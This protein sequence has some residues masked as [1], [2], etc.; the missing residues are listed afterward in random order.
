MSATPSPANGASGVFYDTPL[1]MKFNNPPALGTGTMR[2]YDSGDT[3]VD[4]IDLSQNQAN[5]AQNRTIGGATYYSYPVI[6]RGNHDKA[7]TGLTDLAYFNPV[8]QIAAR[9]TH[10][11]LRPENFSY[12]V[13]PGGTHGPMRCKS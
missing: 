4:T 3:L 12:M 7:V 2:V 10:Q 11:Q 5:N 6:I 13:S 9:W 8:A 1:Y